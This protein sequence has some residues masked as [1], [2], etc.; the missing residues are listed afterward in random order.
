MALQIRRGPRTDRLGDGSPQNPG[1]YFAEGELIFDTTEKEVYIGDGPPGTMDGGTLGGKPITTFT[2][3]QAKDAAA[4]TLT[5]N[6]LHSNISFTYNPTTKQ[7]SAI[8]ALDGTY[9][10]L[11]LDTTPQLGGILD[12]NGFNVTG[13]GNITITGTVTASSLTG[14]LTGN[15]T[16]NIVGNVTG[17]LTGN[18]TG[19]VVGNVTGGLTGNVTGTVSSLSNHSTTA[20]AEGA[21][22]YFTTARAR[23]VISVSGNLTYD[24]NTGVL[25][26][27]APA[28]PSTD[29]IAEGTTNLYFT[30]AR[31]RAAISG[32][33]D[34]S[35]NSSTG[36]I[37]LSVPLI[38]STDSITEG[39]TNLFYT[40]ARARTAINSG[41]GI[42]YNNVSGQVSI[43]QAIGVTDS[44]TFNTVTA[45]VVG[46]LTGEVNSSS[47]Y[48]STLKSYDALIS[49]D[50]A[51]PIII[52]D[53]ATFSGNVDFQGVTVLDGTE[54]I[55]TS[56]FEFRF[57]TGAGDAY[58]ERVALTP[59]S[60]IA[61]VPVQFG[62]YTTTSRNAIVGANLRAGTIIWN[63]TITAFQGW[64]GTAWVTFTT[65]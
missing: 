33:G 55:S 36:E 26:Y 32:T 38:S 59:D 7:L 17:E 11:I 52:S 5:D 18:V 8:V 31:S 63:T 24:N 10:D 15:V 25:G 41:T 35:Y 12:L 47:A 2:S 65:V 50:L 29:G 16:G 30:T 27:S 40:D 19:N 64:N 62:Q 48:V 45:N 22:L 4:A 28:L 56:K 3:A 13:N 46:K 23:A 51:L 44:V 60:I 53:N 6:N 61:N 39:T 34:V 49:G 57:Y 20:L 54:T 21:N 37:S 1:R 42:L 58:E 9:N 43:P 14:G